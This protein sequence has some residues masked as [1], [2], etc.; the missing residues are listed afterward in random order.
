MPIVILVFSS[1]KLG[2]TGAK[3]RMDIYN[4]FDYIYPSILKCIY[5][6]H[7]KCIYP[8]HLKCIT[9]K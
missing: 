1:G 8:S 9:C 7:L 3:Q 4:G 5:P 2:I 6:R